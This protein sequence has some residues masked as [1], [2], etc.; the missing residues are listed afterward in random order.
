MNL[1]A[2]YL[3]NDQLIL[4][5]MVAYRTQ[6]TQKSPEYKKQSGLL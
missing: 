6:T 1:A 5:K 3:R 4:W 2:D